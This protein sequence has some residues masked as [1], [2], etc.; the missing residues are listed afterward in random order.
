MVAKKTKPCAPIYS[1]YLIAN[2]ML[3]PFNP[4]T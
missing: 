4:T 3:S 2:A 1:H